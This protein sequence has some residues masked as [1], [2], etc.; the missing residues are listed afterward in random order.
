M[1]V[2]AYKDKRDTHSNFIFII[3]AVYGGGVILYVLYSKYYILLCSF[4]EFCFV[5]D[6]GILS[7]Y[8]KKTYP[9]P[10]T[11]FICSSGAVPLHWIHISVRVTFL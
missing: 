2:G 4:G 5:L 9:L 10:S 3:L 7:P 8:I 1:W 11:V 6:R